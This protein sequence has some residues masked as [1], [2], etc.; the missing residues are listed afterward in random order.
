MTMI[1]N[2]LLNQIVKQEG[3]V[4]PDKILN[5][6]HKGV[7]KSLKQDVTSS[8]D[9]MDISFLTIDEANKKIY[10]AGANNPLIYVRNG[11]Q[12]E[13][14]ADKMS[15]GGRQ[16]EEERIFT[17]HELEIL[18]GDKFYIFSDGYQD[19]FGGPK[20]RKFMVKKF[21]QLLFDNSNETPDIQKDRLEKAILDW[22]GEEHEQVDD[23]L[24]VGLK[25]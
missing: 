24:V 10:Y 2:T 1:G 20:G 25:Y 7:R 8:K 4:M 16:E 9:G 19:Q 3:E 17:G 15:I 18:P 5:K 22:M 6:L 13:I 14:K 12:L 23:I 21:K 11:E